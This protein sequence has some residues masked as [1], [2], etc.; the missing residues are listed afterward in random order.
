MK[1]AA[2]AMVVLLAA[3]AGPRS[4]A[5]C[6]S[7]GIIEIATAGSFQQNCP[8]GFCYYYTGGSSLPPRAGSYFWALGIGDP[9]PELVDP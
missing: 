2:F 5:A 9:A 4:Q 8:G 6:L 1:R 7:A 3:I